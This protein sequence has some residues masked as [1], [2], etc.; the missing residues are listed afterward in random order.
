MFLNAQGELCFRRYGAGSALSD[1]EE[2]SLTGERAGT[3]ST[4]SYLKAEC[5]AEKLGR[6]TRRLGWGG[7]TIKRTNTA[8]QRAQLVGLEHTLL[9]SV[10]AQSWEITKK[11]HFRAVSCL[12]PVKH[13]QPV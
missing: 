10:K 4:R 12:T 9:L 7:Y 8:V 11:L 3:L 13:I 1:G 5:A 6:A 2:S